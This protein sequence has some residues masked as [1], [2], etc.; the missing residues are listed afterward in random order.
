MKKKIKV[1]EVY[2]GIT[3]PDMLF[4]MIC[5]RNWFNGNLDGKIPVDESRQAYLYLKELLGV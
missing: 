2:K 5:A 4:D 1:P 3:N